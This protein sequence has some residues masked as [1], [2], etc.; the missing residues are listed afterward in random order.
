[1][2]LHEHTVHV[3]L[4]FGPPALQ[5]GLHKVELLLSDAMWGWVRRTVHVVSALGERLVYGRPLAT[6]R[7]GDLGG[8]RVCRFTEGG[9]DKRLSL[10]R[11]LGLFK[12]FK[13]LYRGNTFSLALF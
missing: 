2:Y 13:V 5:A 6:R 7:A 8:I 11:R 1:M 12:C 3:V 4:H 9:K 10:A